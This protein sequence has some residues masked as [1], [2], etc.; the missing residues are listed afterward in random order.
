[1]KRPL[2]QY[3]FIVFL[4]VGDGEVG[5]LKKDPPGCGVDSRLL[6]ENASS[7]FGP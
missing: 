6:E 3:Y 5:A 7:C 1:M 2:E 4:P